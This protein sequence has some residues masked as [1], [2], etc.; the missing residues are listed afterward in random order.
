MK[1][2]SYRMQTQC[3][4]IWRYLLIVFLCISLTASLVVLGIDLDWLINGP[5]FLTKICARIKERMA[6]ED[7]TDEEELLKNFTIARESIW[8]QVFV[9]IV[10]AITTIFVIINLIGCAGSCILS[11]SLLSGFTIF[12]MLTSILGIAVTCAFIL[13]FANISSDLDSS[14]DPMARDLISQYKTEKHGGT[15]HIIIDSVQRELECCGYNSL[16]D[17]KDA[18]ITPRSMEHNDATD[19]DMMFP[20][21]CC[22]LNVT[23]CTMEDVFNVSCREIIQD[24]YLNPDNVIGLIG[25]SI[26]V[27]VSFM[28][29]TFFI[30][31]VMC[32]IA[33]RSRGTK[34]SIVNWGGA[35]SRD[36]TYST[37]V[38]Q[39]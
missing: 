22:P 32:C 8:L 9:I 12:M 10:V 28:I 4:N 18:V 24:N 29:V 5:E 30:S 17:W 34:W 27:V 31:F 2:P 36:E 23:S 38:I 15:A 13:P 3:V 21:S 11:Y 1:D 37:S 6:N 35:G 25:I 20:A 16:N 39:H 33:R 7:L 19:D 14:L 26:I